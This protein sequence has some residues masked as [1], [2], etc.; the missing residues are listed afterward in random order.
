VTEGFHGLGRILR[1]E[2]GLIQ[3]VQVTELVPPEVLSSLRRSAVEQ[4]G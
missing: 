1:D 4:T 3:L 2:D